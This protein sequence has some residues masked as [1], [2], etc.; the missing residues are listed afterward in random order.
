MPPLYMTRAQ[1]KRHTS[2]LVNFSIDVHFISQ[3]VNMPLLRL[4]NQIVTM[5]QNVKETNEE[6]KEKKPDEAA[7]AEPKDFSRGRVQRFS[8]QTT[9]MTCKVVF[10]WL[11]I[12]LGYLA[13]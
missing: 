4:V 12:W 6:L 13:T 5:H 10:V 2:S 7:A 8:D 9:R 1:L 11:G 3:K